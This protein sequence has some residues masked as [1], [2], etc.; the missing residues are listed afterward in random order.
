MNRIKE[1]LE[2]KGIK[3][4]WLAERLEKSYN[5]VNSYVQNRRQPSLEDLFKISNILDIS[6]AELLESNEKSKIHNHSQV[7]LFKLAE[8]ESEYQ[9]TTN[10][11]LL[12]NVACGHPLFAEENIE[13]EISISTK[14]IRKDKNYFILR[15]YG[16][17]MNKANIDD[18]DL[19]LIRQEQTAENGDR[20]VALID[21]EATIKEYRNDG[22]HIVLLPKS[23]TKKHQPIILTRDFKIQG[24]VERVISLKR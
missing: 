6:V 21:D 15:A 20:V 3:Q 7:G 8:P 9:Q 1:V 13:T 16:D 2:S 11:P 17:S 10:I 14:L 4:T 18:G 19:V 24:I 23:T 12:V 22:N 5:M